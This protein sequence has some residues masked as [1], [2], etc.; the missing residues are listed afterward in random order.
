MILALSDEWRQVFQNIIGIDNIRVLNNGI[1][2]ETFEEAITEPQQFKNSFLFLGR[3]GQRKGA[4][5]LLD[6]IY[7]LK[8]EGKVIKCYMAGDGEVDKLRKIVKDKQLE[9]YIDVV[10]WLTLIRRLI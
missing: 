10:G 7:E 3:I 4:Y 5:D 8:N 6:A 9:D 2:T 1:D